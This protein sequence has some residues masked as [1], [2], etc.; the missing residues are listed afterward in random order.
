[1]AYENSRDEL[2][3]FK[4]HPILDLALQLGWQVDEKARNRGAG[5]ATLVKGGDAIVTF[6]GKYC[7]MFK[8]ISGGKDGT[9]IDLAV[10]EAGTLGKARQLLRELTSTPVETTT[11]STS[12][13]PSPSSSPVSSSTRPDS[14]THDHPEKATHDEVLRDFRSMRRLG[15]DEVPAFLR[16]RG[17]DRIPDHIRG[18]L[19]IDTSRYE[20]MG[21]LFVRAISASE[22]RAAGVE[23]K[24][25]GIKGIYTKGGHAGAWF[26][27]GDAGA[28]IVVVE[29]VVDALSFDIVSD[30]AARY[31]EEGLR[32]S[33]MALRSGGEETCAMLL[34]REFREQNAAPVI[35][36]CDNDRAGS[37][38]HSKIWDL[39]DVEGGP[40]VWQIMPMHLSNDWNEAL[41]LHF[42][43]SVQSPS[44]PVCAPA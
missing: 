29:S 19:R 9:V 16:D 35:L 7:F 2:E 27:R 1:M 14:T 21:C 40:Q 31:R 33:Y 34:L 41:Q 26:A 32:L 28:P 36:A 39:I 24:N 43:K 3:A 4:Q 22:I 25:S 13:T 42:Q 5:S 15:A 17:I 6:K 20:N 37:A 18:Q 30:V 8:S 11:P 44:D 38:Y 10:A 23:R 12:P